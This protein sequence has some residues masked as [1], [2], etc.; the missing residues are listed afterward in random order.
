[1]YALVPFL[2]ALGCA[3]VAT[4]L[5]LKTWRL[6]TAGDVFFHRFILKK[7]G[8]L[9]K[10]GWG[11]LACSVLAL[12]LVAHS[13]WVRYH[14]DAGPGAGGSRSLDEPDRS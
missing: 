7:A 14:E 10:G 3:A 1:M 4:F 6:F 9:S 12:G 11:F 13:G 8:K 2:M 5:A